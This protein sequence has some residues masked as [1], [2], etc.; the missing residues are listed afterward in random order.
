[1]ETHALASLQGDCGPRP[2]PSGRQLQ[3]KKWS[4][5]NEL[6]SLSITRRITLPQPFLIEFGGLL[7]NQHIRMRVSRE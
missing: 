7:K 2:H 6:R 3:N 5:P 4:V 1:M